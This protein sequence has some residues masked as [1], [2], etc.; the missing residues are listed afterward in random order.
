M[1]R[2]FRLAG[3]LRL[4]RLE[5]ERAAAQL[6]VANAETRTAE[7]RRD[8]LTT[9]MGNAALPLRAGEPGWQAAVAARA[10]LTGMVDEATVAVDVAVRR[11]ELVAADWTGARARVA[12]LDKLAERHDALVRAEDDRAEQLLLDEAASRRR[13][14]D[15]R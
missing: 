10:A 6:A 2:Q 11:G 4:R 14:E 8:D 7:R 9:L 5:E 1:Q 3:L 13:T 15:D 12:M